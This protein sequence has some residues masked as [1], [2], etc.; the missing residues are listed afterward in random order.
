MRAE[1]AFLVGSITKEFT[2][3]AILQLVERSLLSL[4]ADVRIYV[5]TFNTHGRRIT[6]EQVL[7]HTAGIPNIIDLAAFD[8]LSRLPHTVRELLDRTRDVP[9]HFEPGTSFRYSDTGYFLLGAIIEKVTGRS[10]AEYIESEIT[11]RLGLTRTR[12]ATHQGLPG[13]SRGY[14][15]AGDSV[16][17]APFIHM[18]VPYAAGALS[19]TVDDLFA[20]HRA[21][22]G[23][24][25][26]APSLLRRAWQGRSLSSGEYSG[27][28]FGFKTCDLVGHRSISHGGFVNGFGAHALMLPDDGLDVIVLVNNQSDVPDAGRLARRIARFLITGSSQ[29]PTYALGADERRRLVGRYQIGPRDVREITDSGGAV[30]ARRNQRRPVRLVAQGPTVLTLESSEG[31]YLLTFS[32]GRDGKAERVR[33]SLGC[34]PVDMAVRMP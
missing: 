2:A 3:A 25:V 23:G 9:L 16:S 4:D 34:E 11:A 8:S 14:A 30:F 10:Y 6:L 28:G 22:R 17:I 33:A 26:I 31:D 5:P 15:I 29:P 18:T 32:L 12:Y 13:M 7:T 1:N 27:Y 20:W 21:L 24:R 19:S